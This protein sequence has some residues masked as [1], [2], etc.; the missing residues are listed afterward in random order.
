LES[1]VHFAPQIW[2]DIGIAMVTGRLGFISGVSEW[3][4]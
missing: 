3:R 2:R 4:H 1:H